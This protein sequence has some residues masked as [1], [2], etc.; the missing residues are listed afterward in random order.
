MRRDISRTSPLDVRS[1]SRLYARLRS[2][3]D[4]IPCLLMR[5]SSHHK[6]WYH[7]QLQ[8]SLQQTAFAYRA[9]KP[10]Y[11]S[12]PPVRRLLIRLLHPAL[13]VG[14]FAWHSSAF[15]SYKLLFRHLRG[16]LLR[17]LE[18]EHSVLE[19]CLDVLLGDIFTYVEA[20]FHRA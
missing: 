2:A 1:L 13:F 14:R 3:L 8:A 7:I 20:S 15:D 10:P 4:M 12:V 19:F 17:Y 16:L 6:P 9:K 11:R 5:A 18:F